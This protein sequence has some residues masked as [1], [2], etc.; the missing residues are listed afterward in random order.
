MIPYALLFALFGHKAILIWTHGVIHS[1]QV[2]L[3]AL[4][5]SI[6]FGGFWFPVSNLILA[7]NRHGSYTG[8]FVGLAFAVMPL[9]WLLSQRFGAGGAGIAMAVLDIAMFMVIVILARRLLVSGHE[10]RA[11]V[12]FALARVRGLRRASPPESAR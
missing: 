6:L 3:W 9:T 10:I 2:L 1:P 11:A 8:W 5:A 4:A 12:P 7:L